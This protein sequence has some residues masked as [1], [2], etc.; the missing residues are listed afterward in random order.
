MAMVASGFNKSVRN[1]A[2][3][4]FDSVAAYYA[5]YT[6]NMNIDWLNAP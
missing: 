3:L 6:Q 4:S 2:T 5:A 1:N